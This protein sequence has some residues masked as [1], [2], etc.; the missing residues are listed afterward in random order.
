MDPDP[1]HC[2]EGTQIYGKI[3]CRVVFI[4]DLLQEEYPRHMYEEVR[5]FCH[6]WNT[7]P[8][9][10]GFTS[11]RHPPPHLLL[12]GGA[13]RNLSGSL[14][15]PPEPA[16]QQ[17]VSDYLPALTMEE[18]S[19]L[20]SPESADSLLYPEEDQ[21]QQQLEGLESQEVWTDCLQLTSDL[22]DWME[23]DTLTALQF[24]SLYNLG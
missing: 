4:L 2:F 20:H 17:N 6:Q 14:E 18:L 23:T 24:P 15:L 1:Q 8:E 9:G 7:D 5:D 12:M 21:P 16:V 10:S 19:S 3:Y 22:P 13:I 11:P